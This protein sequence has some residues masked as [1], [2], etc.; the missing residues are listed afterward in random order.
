MAATINWLSVRMSSIRRLSDEDVRAIFE[1]LHG[2]H[3][4]PPHL[5]FQIVPVGPTALRLSPPSY[6]FEG[7]K[8]LTNSLLFVRRKI[9]S[10]FV[11]I[12][13]SLQCRWSLCVAQARQEEKEFP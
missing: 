3:Q 12:S 13:I 7:E 8:V 9:D 5:K 11:F 10:D 1:S 4:P 2:D 6:E